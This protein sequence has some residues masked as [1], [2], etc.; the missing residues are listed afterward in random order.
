MRIKLKQLWE[1]IHKILWVKIALEVL[2]DVG[3]RKN[4]AKT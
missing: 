3:V 4:D 1:P 2:E